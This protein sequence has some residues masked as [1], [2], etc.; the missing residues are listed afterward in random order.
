M[1]YDT[2]AAKQ[3]DY[4]N[5]KNTLGSRRSR[6]IFHAKLRNWGSEREYDEIVRANGGVEPRSYHR[7]LTMRQRLYSMINLRTI[8]SVGLA[9]FCRC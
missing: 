7:P 8:T 2:E 1:K 3:A 6:S 5:D 4:K 9:T